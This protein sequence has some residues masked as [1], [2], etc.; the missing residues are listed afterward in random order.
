MGVDYA[1]DDVVIDVSGLTSDDFGDGD[2]LVFG[3]VG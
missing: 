1:W 3:F 2:S